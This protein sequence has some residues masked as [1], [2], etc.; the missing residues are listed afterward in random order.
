MWL[1][2]KMVETDTSVL[3]D[4]NVVSNIVP[5]II[6]IHIGVLLKENA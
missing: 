2:E 6:S 4:K 1:I 3:W 5:R